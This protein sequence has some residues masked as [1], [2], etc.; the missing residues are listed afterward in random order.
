M[1]GARSDL[2]A[3]LTHETHLLTAEG[4]TRDQSYREKFL[5][6]NGHVWAER[7]VPE[8]ARSSGE[9]NHEHG[10]HHHDFNFNLAARHIFKNKQGRV[11]VSFVDSQDRV[12]VSV[13]AEEHGSVGFDGS[14]ES[15]YYL[16]NPAVVRKLAPGRLSS[17]VDG[18]RWYEK[19]DKDAYF[20][21]LW[22]EKLQLPMVIESGSQDG[23]RRNRVSVE[24]VPLSPSD[25]LPWL[26]LKDFARKEYSDLLD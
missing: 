15:A 26:S 24:I 9:A 6:Q 12:I 14:W 23:L 3:V 2:A 16:V 11:E 10:L 8:R 7:I 1:G 13:P 4:V 22:S 20:R 21:V 19:N 17:T 5:R 18:A 25:P